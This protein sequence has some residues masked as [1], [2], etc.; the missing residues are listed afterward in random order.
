MVSYK[1][2]QE[3]SSICFCFFFLSSPAPPN[4]YLWNPLQHVCT[5]FLPRQNPCSTTVGVSLPMS[6][7]RRSNYLPGLF[8]HT[9]TGT[10]SSNPAYAELHPSNSSQSGEDRVAGRQSSTYTPTQS[11]LWAQDRN[12]M[13]EISDTNTIGGFRVHKEMRW[14]KLD[15]FHT[16]ILCHR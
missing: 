12:W 14:H 15:C 10:A 5:S 11:N 7:R 16:I 3:H 2:Q 13:I 1:K 8:S 9:W 4:V 6:L